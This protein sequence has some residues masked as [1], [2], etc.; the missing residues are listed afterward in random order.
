MTAD[1]I[2][3][4]YRRAFGTEATGSVLKL[5]GLTPADFA[6]VAKE[7]DRAGLNRPLWKRRLTR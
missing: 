1:Q 7:G 6:R 4:A 3:E 2:A 5:S